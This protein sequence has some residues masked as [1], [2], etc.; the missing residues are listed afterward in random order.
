M[1]ICLYFLT[2]R[3]GLGDLGG[4]EGLPWNLKNMLILPANNLK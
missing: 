3:S 4:I 1:L 2:L